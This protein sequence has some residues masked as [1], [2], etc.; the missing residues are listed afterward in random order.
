[1]VS[2][3]ITKWMLIYIILSSTSITLI[4]I[5][6]K[7]PDN[8]LIDWWGSDFENSNFFVDAIYEG[9][10]NITWSEHFQVLDDDGVNVTLLRIRFNDSDV[11]QQS[12]GILMSGDMYNGFYDAFFTWDLTERLYLFDVKIFADDTIGNWV[13][14]PILSVSYNIIYRDETAS[15][16]LPRNPPQPILML[17]PIFAVIF[18]LIIVGYYLFI[19]AQQL[20]ESRVKTQTQNTTVSR[21]LIDKYPNWISK[22]IAT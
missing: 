13:E 16:T 22:H 6:L 21:P 9:Q 14:T 19:R 12:Q 10:T 1:M 15:T 11:W 8:L 4:E 7:S 20:T 3:N 2:R 5:H 17:T 18:I